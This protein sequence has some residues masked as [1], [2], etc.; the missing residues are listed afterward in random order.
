[1]AEQLLTHRNLA[2]TQPRRYEHVL[3]S[4]DADVV[5]VE[6]NIAD[7]YRR[8]LLERRVPPSETRNRMLVN[9]L[10]S[11]EDNSTSGA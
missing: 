10:N 1:M 3:G 7:D 2:A 4:V 11:R 5:E 6:S 8:F 9:W